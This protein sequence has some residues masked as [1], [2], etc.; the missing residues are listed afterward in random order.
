MILAA[1]ALAQP[2]VPQQSEQV[3]SDMPFRREPVVGAGDVL[4]VA[5]GLAVALLVAVGLI[6]LLR[7]WY[8][9]GTGPLGAR[10]IQVQEARKVT[11]RTTAAI[12]VV[13]GRELLLVESAGAVAVHPLQ[14]V[15]DHDS[16]Q[17]VE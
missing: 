2:A 8:G 9:T 13:D 16:E 10:R 15:P 6:L 7:R 3:Q 12:I 17:K 11:R 1:T 14:P 5:I 4:Q